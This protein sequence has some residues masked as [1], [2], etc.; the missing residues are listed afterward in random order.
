MPM[1]FRRLLLRLEKRHRPH[2]WMFPRRR[3]L[4]LKI[5]LHP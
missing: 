2:Q 3:L 5:R 1:P 4:V